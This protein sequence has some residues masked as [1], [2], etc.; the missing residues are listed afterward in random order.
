GKQNSHA[1]HSLHAPRLRRDLLGDGLRPEPQEDGTLRLVIVELIEKDESAAEQEDRGHERRLEEGYDQVT[2]GRAP[3]AARRRAQND[4]R[5]LWPLARSAVRA[6]AALTAS[7]GARE[8]A[9][10]ADLARAQP[11]ASTRSGCRGR[12]S[13]RAHHPRRRLRRSDEA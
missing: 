9:R 12:R 5:A 11:L 1:P 6:D 3:R 4:P 10:H 8:R 13:I 7:C 2:A